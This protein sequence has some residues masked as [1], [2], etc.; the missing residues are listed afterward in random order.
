MTDSSDDEKKLKEQLNEL[1]ETATDLV[2]RNRKPSEKYIVYVDDNF[3]FMDEDSRYTLG[4]FDTE[5]E[6]IQAAKAVIDEFLLKDYNE[7]STPESLLEGY[8]MFGEDPF[9]PG[10]IFN[11]WDYAE[12]RCKELCNPSQDNQP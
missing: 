5:E 4:E 6:A 8:K 2:K 10:V 7:K 9:I 12:K 1:Y 3:N 11:A